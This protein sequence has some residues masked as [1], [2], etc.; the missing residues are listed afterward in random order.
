MAF[1]P[2][3]SPELQKAAALIRRDPLMVDPLPPAGRSLDESHRRNKSKPPEKDAPRAG[4]VTVSPEKGPLSTHLRTSIPER[5][6][7]APANAG[8]V[9]LVSNDDC[10]RSTV[11]AYLEH[12]GFTVRS[13]ADAARVPDLFFCRPGE[14]AAAERGGISGHSSGIDLLLM[15]VH[16]LGATG[17]R[18]AAALTSFDPD[19][20]VI[21]ISAADAGK[22][23]WAGMARRGWKFL[24][25]PVLVP[26]LLGVIY[27]ALGARGPLRRLR[28]AQPASNLD[29]DAPSGAGRRTEAVAPAPDSGLEMSLGALNTRGTAQ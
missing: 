13:C 4:N 25:T 26:E 12:E 8:T 10:L 11:R 14:P 20:P 2:I 23:A 19:L 22:N 9:L 1:P 28:D 29:E 7:E 5:T 27:T 3:P 15:D 24:N 18:L 6:A 21:V 17:L 16:A